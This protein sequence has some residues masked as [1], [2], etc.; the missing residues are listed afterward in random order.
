VI[1]DYLFKN[2]VGSELFYYDV[3]FEYEH[4]EPTVNSIHEDFEEKITSVKKLNASDYLVDV[5][6]EVNS[7]IDFFIDKSDYWS[8]D[9]DKHISIQDFDW[10]K[11]LMFAETEILVPLSM[12]LI[13]DSDLNVKSCQINKINENYAQQYV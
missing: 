5:E 8:M 12:S 9:D 1:T 13:I 10:N 3:E 6:L 4:S 11:W 7:I 2:Y